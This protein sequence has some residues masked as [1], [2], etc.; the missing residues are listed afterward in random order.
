MVKQFCE[1]RAYIAN[2]GVKLLQELGADHEFE[3]LD[4]ACFLYK[5]ILNQ[6]SFQLLLNEFA[7][8][9]AREN[10]LHRLGIAPGQYTTQHKPSQKVLQVHCPGDEKLGERKAGASGGSPEKEKPADEPAP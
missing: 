7:E 6:D 3:K 10:V 2:Q 5:H 9:D 8:A 4:L 1:G